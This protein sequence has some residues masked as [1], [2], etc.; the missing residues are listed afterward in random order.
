MGGGMLTRGPAPR[1]R[2]QLREAAVALGARYAPDWSDACTHLLCAFPNT[3][4]HR[5]AFTALAARAA[6][7]SERSR[8]HGASARLF[9]ASRSQLG[10]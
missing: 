9:K 8:V 10:L 6:L 1:R 4:K 5:C 2:G 3:P 7:R